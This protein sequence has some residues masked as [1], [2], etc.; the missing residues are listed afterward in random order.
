VVDP[1]AVDGGSAAMYAPGKILKSGRS[2]DPDQPVIPSTATTY[3]LDMSQS[4]PR[5]RQTPPMAFPRTFHTLTL[6]PDGTVLSTGG[7]PNTD[8]VGVNNAVLA[9]ELWS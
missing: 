9:A 8:A 4:T 1:N 6:L 5:W 2:V 7:G 3:V